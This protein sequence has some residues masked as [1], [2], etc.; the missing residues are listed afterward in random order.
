MGTNEITGE[1]VEISARDGVAF[2]EQA[3]PLTR[4]H[5]FDGQFPV[6]YTHL[7]VY[8]R[9]DHRRPGHLGY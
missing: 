7:D 5:F 4:L 9:Q 6:S 3:S 2:I 1:T 8:K